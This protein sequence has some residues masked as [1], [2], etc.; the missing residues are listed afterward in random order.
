MFLGFLFVSLFV[1]FYSLFVS[2]RLCILSVV[3]IKIECALK[4]LGAAGV[5]LMSVLDGWTPVP[6]NRTPVNTPIAH[7]ESC[8]FKSRLYPGEGASCLSAHVC[9]FLSLCVSGKYSHVF[10]N[11][12][13]WGKKL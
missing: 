13:W 6:P 10:F 8:V 1:C 3:I 4:E 5:C 12:P 9:F 11:Q 7:T 2:V